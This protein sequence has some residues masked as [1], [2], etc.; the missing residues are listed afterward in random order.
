MAKAQTV[1]QA[2]NPAPA[3]ETAATGDAPAP[4]QDQ[5][6]I[7]ALWIKARSQS[8]RR[9]GYRFT[10]E[11]MGIALSALTDEEQEI[12]MADPNLIVEEVTGF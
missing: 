11:G 6:G 10:A 1:K 7:P 2:A 12:L 4:D 9:C 3:T 5:D 8:I